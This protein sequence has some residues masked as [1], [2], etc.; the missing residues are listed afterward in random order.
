MGSEI[1]EVTAQAV[2]F[3]DE[4]TSI[5]D[6]TTAT[7]TLR[8]E[9]GAIGIISLDRQ[10]A[11]GYDQRL[12]V[13]G[14]KGSAEIGNR[15]GNTAVFQTATEVKK[16]LPLNFFMDRYE[17][18]YSREVGA[19]VDAIRKDS[20]PVVSGADGRVPIVVALAAYKSLSEK[21]TVHVSEI[22]ASVAKL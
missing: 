17:L 2:S 10:A 19:F 20:E 18:A 8:F 6:Y 15:F 4:V 3:N 14:S 12:E 5:G 22:K 7:L 13:L 9:N 16:D 21:R 1:T 11:Y